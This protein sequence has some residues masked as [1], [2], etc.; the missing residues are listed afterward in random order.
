MS[1]RNYII[2]LTCVGIAAGLGYHSGKT[3]GRDE[4]LQKM[5]ESIDRIVSDE[6]THVG[7]EAVSSENEG[8]QTRLEI[9]R[10]LLKRLDNYL[11]YNTITILED[12]QKPRGQRGFIVS[13][14]DEAFPSDPQARFKMWDY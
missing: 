4:G 11:D 1:F 10:D 2:G 12:A 14:T 7:L 3:D 9:Q 8:R 13:A 5:K 6:R